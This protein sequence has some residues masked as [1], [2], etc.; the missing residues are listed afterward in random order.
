MTPIAVHYQP[1]Y[2]FIS[3]KINNTEDAQDLTQEVFYKL[4]NNQH[5]AIEN[6]QHWLFRIAKNT[7]IDYYRKKKIVLEEIS[8][9]LEWDGSLEDM[10]LSELQHDRLKN[11]LVGLIN[12]LPHNYQQIIRMSDIEG[13]SQK[14]IA[15]ELGLNYAT[16]RSTVQRA[17]LLL[18]KMILDCCEIIQGGK[19][20]IIGY[21]PKLENCSCGCVKG[22]INYL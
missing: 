4:L 8:P 10:S 3:S 21:R 5:T 13:L 16:V 2:R 12:Q 19:G 15:E 11:Y 20:S 6:E 22:E 14:E 1:I 18:K 7:V 17:R 9:E